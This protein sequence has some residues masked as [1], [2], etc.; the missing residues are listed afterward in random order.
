MMVVMTHRM[1][2]PLVLACLALGVSQAAWPV[3]DPRTVAGDSTTE[4]RAAA[5]RHGLLHVQD[6]GSPGSTFRGRP[7]FPPA[8][9]LFEIDGTRSAPANPWPHGAPW[10]P[11]GPATP[12]ATRGHPAPS[13][14]PRG[15]APPTASDR[16]PASREYGIPR[17]SGTPAREGAVWGATRGD[18]QSHSRGDPWGDP[19]SDSRGDPW[20]DNRGDPWGETR[21]DPRWTQPPHDDARGAE[22]AWP[23]A[24]SGRFLTHPEFHPDHRPTHDYPA[25]HAPRSGDTYG[26]HPGQLEFAPRWDD[27]H[28]SQWGPARSE[29]GGFGSPTGGPAGRGFERPR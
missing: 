21:G 29:P 17:S 16:P 26:S 22:H 3:W 5:G 4:D 23:T 10:S 6:R 27:T 20:S 25:P 19:W 11:P 12:S 2:G 7:E 28:D 8:D 13:V 9:H 14:T 1:I 15:F 18:S 24:P